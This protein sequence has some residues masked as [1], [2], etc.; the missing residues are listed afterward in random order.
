MYS[1]NCLPEGFK[2]LQV[3]KDLSSA[4]DSVFGPEISGAINAMAGLKTLEE[5]SGNSSTIGSGISNTVFPPANNVVFGKGDGLST[6]FQ[7]VDSQDNSV[8]SASINSIYKSDWQGNQLQYSTPR[9]NLIDASNN[10]SAI[11]WY[12]VGET[13]TNTTTTGPDGVANSASTLTCSVS[14]GQATLFDNSYVVVSGDIQIETSIWVKAGNISGCVLQSYQN[15]VG[16]VNANWSILSGPGTITGNGTGIG[17]VSGLTSAWTRIGIIT[18]GALTAGFNFNPYISA[19]LSSGSPVSGGYIYLYGAQL[20]KSG[21]VTSL[22]PT[23]SGPVTV[24]DYS[25]SSSQIIFST[26]P[27]NLAVL[28]AET[29]RAAVINGPDLWGVLQVDLYGRALIDFSQTTHLNKNLDNIPDGVTRFAVPAATVAP[30][31]T[32][33]VSGTVYQNT[34]GGPI[35][36]YIPINYIN[37]TIAGTVAIFLG[38]SSTPGVI[39]GNESNLGVTAKVET[40]TLMVPNNWYYKVVVNT[41]ATIG[42]VYQVKGI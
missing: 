19:Y 21:T 34:T 27:L 22:I 18:T 31:T 6:V 5:I 29:G 3:W 12:I 26:A 30:A 39:F 35:V 16:G 7:L 20:E 10:F 33:L 17:T 25:L 24:T 40:I 4:V 38:P 23:T 32:A 14:T 11:N 15:G 41:E 37:A 2:D 13:I 9:T 42:T 36:L 8:T 28:T 1:L